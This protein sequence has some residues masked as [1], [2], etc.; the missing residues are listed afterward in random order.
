[1]EVLARELKI[2]SDYGLIMNDSVSYYLLLQWINKKLVNKE[3]VIKFDDSFIKVPRKVAI[4]L[5]HY[6]EIQY[7]KLDFYSFG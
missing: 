4:D 3:D 6:L 7:Q 1:M 5:K 2:E